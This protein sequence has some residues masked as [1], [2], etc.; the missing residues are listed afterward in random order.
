MARFVDIE[1]G[2]EFI[3]ENQRYVKIKNKQ[4]TCC[5]VLN[6]RK[7]DETNKEVMIVPITE[8]EVVDK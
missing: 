4:I 6:A 8:V 1:V 2:T 7:L 3:H 5:K